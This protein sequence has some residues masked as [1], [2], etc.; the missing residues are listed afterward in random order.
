MK[1]FGCNVENGRSMLSRKRLQDEGSHLDSEFYLVPIS[2]NYMRVKQMGNRSPLRYPGG[3]AALA[4]LLRAI[5]KRNRL[6]GCKIVEPFAGGGGA[7][8]DLLFNGA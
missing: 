6:E 4:G 3:K 1:T 7:S 8:L 5:L 2:T